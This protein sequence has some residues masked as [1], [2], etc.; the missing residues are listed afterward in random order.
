MILAIRIKQLAILLTVAALSSCSTPA[1]ESRYPVDEMLD[2][3]T[4]EVPDVILPR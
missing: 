4:E 3:V 1:P 2:P